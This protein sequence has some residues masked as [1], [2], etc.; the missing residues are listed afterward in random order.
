LLE[1]E[2]RTLMISTRLGMPK[3]SNS[4]FF[5]GLIRNLL[6]LVTFSNGQHYSQ[7]DFMLARREDSH[8]CLD[9]KVI[10]GES[11]MPQI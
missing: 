5:E 3:I 2:H 6:H 8:I 1:S 10:L 11:V 7:I 9:C 4:N